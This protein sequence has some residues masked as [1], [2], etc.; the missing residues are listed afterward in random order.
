MYFIHLHKNAIISFHG[1][2][3]LQNMQNLEISG[4]FK[5]IS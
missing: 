3:L 2:F 1:F 5:E 4:K